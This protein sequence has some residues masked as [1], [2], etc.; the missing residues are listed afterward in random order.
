MNNKNICSSVIL[1]GCTGQVQTSDVCI[2]RQFKAKLQDLFDEFMADESQHTFTKGGNM[3]S[4]S[5]TRLCDMVVKAWGEITPVMVMNSFKVC[6]QMPGCNVPDILPFRD[7]KACAEGRSKVESLWD[8]YP[9]MIDLDLLEV[10]AS[11]EEM[12]EMVE[13]DKNLRR[14]TRV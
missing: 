9:S 11:V 3:R 2:S 5:K 13:V 1:G 7:G 10:K 8:F 6:G 4:A 12:E 14:I